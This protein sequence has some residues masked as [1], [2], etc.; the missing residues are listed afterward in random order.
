LNRA[1]IN[2]YR[3]ELIEAK[4][5]KDVRES[6]I[7]WQHQEAWQHVHHAHKRAFCLQLCFC[8]PILQLPVTKFKTLTN[9][10]LNKTLKITNTFSNFQKHP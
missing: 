9:N 1:F 4:P 3:N 8:A 10:L 6:S 2:R 5:S 7:S